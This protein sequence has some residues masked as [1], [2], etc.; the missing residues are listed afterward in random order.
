[1]TVRFCNIQ[2]SDIMEYLVELRKPVER[3]Q[4]RMHQT[5]INLNEI[6]RI[7]SMWLKQPLFVR[8]DGKK[9]GMLCLNERENRV[10]KRYTEI[11]TASQTVHR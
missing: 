7:T 6:K 8:K 1:M 4:I 5:Q 11:E 10:I 3:L 9:D 2:I